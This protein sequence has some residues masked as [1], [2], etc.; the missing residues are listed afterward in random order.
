MWI[1]KTDQSSLFRQENNTLNISKSF[2]IS[3][4]LTYVPYF[5]TGSSAASEKSRFDNMDTVACLTKQRQQQEEGG[6]ALRQHKNIQKNLSDTPEWISLHQE[7][8][9]NKI[10]TSTGKLIP[11]CLDLAMHR[12]VNKT[13][14]SG[15]GDENQKAQGSF[16]NKKPKVKEGVN[17]LMSENHHSESNTR[18]NLSAGNSLQWMKEKHTP[19][20][21]GGNEQ[22]NS[23]PHG[24]ERFGCS[25]ARTALRN[26]LRYIVPVLPLP[27][28]R[29]RRK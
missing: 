4:M 12:S 3:H 10:V 28:S 1:R 13:R 21:A 17:N 18:N 14:T 22:H 6:Q 16:I 8:Q 26:K 11:Q 29:E 23:K 5:L 7:G 27:H 2:V 24:S 25:A 20:E 19:S 15:N 9:A